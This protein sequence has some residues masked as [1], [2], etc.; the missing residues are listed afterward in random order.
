MSATSREPVDK[1]IERTYP[2]MRWRV[3]SLAADLDRIQRADGGH[4]LANDARLLALQECIAELASG[5]PGRAER[6]QLILSDMTPPPEK[7]P[8]TK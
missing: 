3:L 2:E 8:P 1:L 6:V 5:E 4:S 7:L